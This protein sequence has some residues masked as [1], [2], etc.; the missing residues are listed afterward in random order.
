MAGTTKAPSTPF[1]YS[2]TAPLKLAPNE[3][4]YVAT[5]LTK[6]FTVYVEGD[7]L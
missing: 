7:D 1:P 5:G 6:N 2:P 3:E 4:L